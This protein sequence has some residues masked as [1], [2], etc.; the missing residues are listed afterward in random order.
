M[1]WSLTG[2]P[3]L[4]VYAIVYYQF[5]PFSNSIN[6]DIIVISKGE[7]QFE[8]SP[9]GSTNKYTFL[10][11]TCTYK[12]AT[13]RKEGQKEGKEIDMWEYFIASAG[14]FQLYY[15]IFLAI[16]FPTA[17][18]CNYYFTIILQCFLIIFQIVKSQGCLVS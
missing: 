6:T 12:F 4:Y 11:L 3:D 10:L 8:D 14:H 2:N 7:L 17:I 5:Y 18:I 1:F 13:Q 15:I 16:L 9:Y